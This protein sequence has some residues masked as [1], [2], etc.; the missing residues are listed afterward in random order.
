M[1]VCRAGQ[2]IPYKR[3]ANIFCKLEVSSA[4][5]G[6]E[7]KFRTGLKRINQSSNPGAD[8]HRTLAAATGG[9]IKICRRVRP[10]FFFSAPAGRAEPRRAVLTA[11]RLIL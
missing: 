7:T 4:T 3:R 8:R 6:H 11:Q 1:P 2:K 10:E 5:N 9:G